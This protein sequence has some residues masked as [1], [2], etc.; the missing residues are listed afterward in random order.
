MYNSLGAMNCECKKLLKRTLFLQLTAE[1][2]RIHSL[3][4]TEPLVLFKGGAVRTLDALLAA[5]Q[6]EIENVISDEVIR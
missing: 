4:Y 3:P 5:P 1:V 6:Q 2:Y